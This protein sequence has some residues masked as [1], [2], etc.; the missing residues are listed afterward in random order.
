MDCMAVIHRVSRCPDNGEG[1]AKHAHA[2]AHACA[3]THMHVHT[4]THTHVYVHVHN[5]QHSYM[6]MYTQI[7]IVTHLCA[8]ERVLSYRLV[9]TLW[10][11][12]KV[13]NCPVH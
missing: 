6:Y 11:D 5:Y 7:C 13:V 3:Y 1:E 9:A 8:G 4:H 10:V 2:H 12:N